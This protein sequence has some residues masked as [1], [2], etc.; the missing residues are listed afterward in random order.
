MPTFISQNG[1]H[2]AAHNLPTGIKIQH[3]AIETARTYIQNKLKVQL[4]LSRLRQN[5]SL[6]FYKSP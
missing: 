2:P 3:L 5:L 1:L 4:G 6:L